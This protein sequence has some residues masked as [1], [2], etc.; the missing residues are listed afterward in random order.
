VAIAAECCDCMTMVTDFRHLPRA[1]GV[2]SMSPTSN[3]APA[4]QAT[5]PGTVER[6]TVTGRRRL[7][8]IVTACVGIGLVAAPAASATAAPS[9]TTV[10]TTTVTSTTNA[11]G[12]KSTAA[13]AC[14]GTTYVLPAGASWY[15]L[16][17]TTGVKLPVLLAAN[18]AKLATKLYP[19]RPICLP[20]GATLPTASTTTSTP[21]SAGKTGA[22]K[23]TTTSTTTTTVAVHLISRAESEAIIRKIW[24]ADVADVAVAIATR[25]S[26]LQNTA[27]N[28]CCYGLFQIHFQANQKLL[29]AAGVTSPAQL[30]DA[31]TNAYLAY[32]MYLRSGWAP[33]GGPID[34]G[35]G[36]TTTTG[37]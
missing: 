7:A 10:T 23:A 17:R 11:P 33:W 3:P 26:D 30:L 18:N 28:S 32:S 21:T 27:K 13:R 37:G 6:G 14:N 8:V 2:M 20:K 25:E 4:E 22:G 16:A 15:A 35:G 1:K 19:G 24:P 5:Q 29:N 12:K 34:L 31:T 9:R 36:T